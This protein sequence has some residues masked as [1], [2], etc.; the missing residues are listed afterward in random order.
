[1]HYI[2]KILDL[3]FPHVLSNNLKVSQDF[4]ENYA[5]YKQKNLRQAFDFFKGKFL[6]FMNI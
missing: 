3:K 6:T 1:M 2:L 4:N 5:F